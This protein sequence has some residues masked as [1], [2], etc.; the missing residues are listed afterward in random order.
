MKTRTLSFTSAPY[1]AL[2]LLPTACGDS[3]QEELHVRRAPVIFDQRDTYQSRVLMDRAADPALSVEKRK[4]F[5]QS[6]FLSTGSAFLEHT[7]ALNPQQSCAI[8]PLIPVEG[9]AQLVS[10]TRLVTAHHVVANASNDMFTLRFDGSD[11]SGY[12]MTDPDNGLRDQENPLLA[13][14]LWQLGLDYWAANSPI[15]RNDTRDE[16]RQWNAHLDLEGYDSAG[17][18]I[19][20]QP[21]VRNANARLDIAFLAV[22]EKD[23]PGFPTTGDPYSRPFY[24]KTGRFTIDQP[25]L[26]FN[27]IEADTVDRIFG[28]NKKVS[29]YINRLEPLTPLQLL[30]APRWMDNSGDISPQ[31]AVV[32]CVS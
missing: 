26:F 12:W 19:M 13:N 5:T 10:P 27:Q 20:D 30:S 18:A 29:Q 23:I 1:L 9:S 15:H 17:S 2:L 31:H 28:Q 4:R 6:A 16:L 14:R 22:E 24:L 32:A 25:G 11:A 8:E 7:D 21:F 3:L